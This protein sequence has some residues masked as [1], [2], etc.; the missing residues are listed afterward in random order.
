MITRLYIGSNN[1]THKVEK[2]KIT[3]ILNN[4]LDGYSIINTVGY[5]QGINEKSVIVEI[6]NEEVK[7][8]VIQI[9]KEDLQQYSI[10]VTV[11]TSSIV[12]FY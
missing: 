2:D 9:L 3:I 7:K 5:W 12:T 10:L 6:I 8:E 1:T 11:D 4:Y